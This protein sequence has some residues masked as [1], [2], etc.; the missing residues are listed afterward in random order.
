MRTGA[1]YRQGLRDGRRVW[2]LGEGPVED[3]TTHPA[4][5][6][7]VD[8]YA[9]WYDRHAD[10][11]WQ[12][13]LLTQPDADG[14]RRPLAF[15][16]PRSPEDLRRL[17]RAI[18]AVAFTNAGNITHTPG[19][20]ALI[21]LGVLDAVKT[22][23]LPPDRVAAAEAYRDGIAK[24]GRFVTFATGSPVPADRFRGADGRAAAR[25]LRERD[26]GV[27][28]G[29]MAGLHTAVPF[30]DEVLVTA[31]MWSPN[32]GDRI[33]FS[34]P[35]NADGVRVVARR[36]ASRHQEKFVAPLSSRFDELDAQLWLD[37]VFIPWEK[38]FACRFEP[39][40]GPDDARRRDGIVSWLLWHQQLGWLARA[41]FTLGLALAVADA[42]G[43]KSIQGVVDNLVDL[44]VDVETIRAA[45][46]AA[47]LN[48][49]LS[50][51]GYLLPRL[52]HLAP[53]ALRTFERRQRMAEILR[54]LLGQAGVLCPTDADL[55]DDR[56]AEDLE[57]AFGGGG[58]T[59]RQ[60][61]ALLQL[62]WDHVSSGLDGREAAFEALANGGTPVWRHR[63]QRWFDRYDE[64]ANG[65]LAA[66]DL[67]MPRIGVDHL[68]DVAPLRR[69]AS[70]PAKERPA[71]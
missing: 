32:A 55:A 10:P 69:G 49:E 3:V 14:N 46:T 17:G 41:E 47:E 2:I 22:M 63:L 42:M 58:Y 20:G 7:M 61:T 54:N 23:G 36:T 15:L 27:I 43:L 51:A 70:L 28:V 5:S 45:L 26:G 52:L 62:A 53:A 25:L 21:A 60:R 12:D 6:A 50:Q 40:A 11:A 37:D 1:D 38:V 30:A 34:V 16:I 48:P 57:L 19:Y 24:T 56:L 66:L 18:H 31:G 33:W 44:V 29:G 68:R 4:T 9:A 67:E 39:A 71:N 35:V 8:A 59:A 65:V 13:V 64:L